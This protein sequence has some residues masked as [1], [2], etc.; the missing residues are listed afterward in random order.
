MSTSIIYQVLTPLLFLSEGMHA[1]THMSVLFGLSNSSVQD[2]NNF[3]VY[4][5]WDGLSHLLPYFLHKRFLPYLF[6]EFLG[7]MFYF[8]T[9]NKNNYYTERIKSWSSSEYKGDYITPDFFLTIS[10][11]IGHLLNLYAL[12]SLISTQNVL[13]IG[14][15][16][17]LTYPV[18]RIVRYHH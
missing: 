13:L 1:G 18:Y 17:V 11:I 14:F 9:W 6:F 8:F 2:Y 10:D 15:F 12:S 3:G 4:F 7:H 5:L 16:G